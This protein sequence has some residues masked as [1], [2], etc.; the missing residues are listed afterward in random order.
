DASLRFEYGHQ[1]LE[2]FRHGW[3]DESA[4]RRELL[5]PIARGADYLPSLRDPGSNRATRAEPRSA[6]PGTILLLSGELL[7]GRGLP[8]DYVVHLAVG[9]AARARRTP[10]ERAWTLPAFVDY[11]EEARPHEVADALVRVDDPRRPAVS[12][13]PGRPTTDQ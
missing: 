11:D 9:P 8:F 4:L 6:R 12:W 3:L 2:S 1:Y 13:S 7:L 10:P 5:E